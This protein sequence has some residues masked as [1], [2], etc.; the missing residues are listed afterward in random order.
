MTFRVV[1]VRMEY[2]VYVPDS[3]P[4]DQTVQAAIDAEIPHTLDVETTG[5]IVDGVDHAP[6]GAFVVGPRQPRRG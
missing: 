3:I 1:R 4:E 6:R 2:T 5:E